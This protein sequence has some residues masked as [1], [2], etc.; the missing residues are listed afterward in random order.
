MATTAAGLTYGRGMGSFF[1]LEI[2]FVIV[3]L[4]VISL[5]F[6]FGIST[7]KSML[8]RLDEI[9]LRWKRDCW[10]IVLENSGQYLNILVMN[11]TYL[12]I[13]NVTRTY[14]S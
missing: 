10:K 2:V 8:S 11:C 9:K 3:L 13:T 5:T 4:L 1:Q 7:I 12:K 14:I 6:T